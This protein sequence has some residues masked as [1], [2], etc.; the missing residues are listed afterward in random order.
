V[1]LLAPGTAEAL[2]YCH[3][4]FLTNLVKL[5]Y[6]RSMNTY[7]I[8]EAKTNFS[9]LVKR[10]A[11]GETILV[12]AYGQPTVEIKAVSHKPSTKSLRGIWAG[13]FKLP[14]DWDKLDSRIA[15]SMINSDLGF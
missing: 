2:I 11:A 10:A 6:A 7:T 12:G 3:K 8:Y 9:S 4:S 1:K 13:K 5:C 15:A 14:A